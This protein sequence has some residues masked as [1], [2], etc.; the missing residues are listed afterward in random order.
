MHVSWKQRTIPFQ[1]SS[2]GKKWEV[3]WLR[4]AAS[5]LKQS[6]QK[7]VGTR[8]KDRNRKQR[9]V[10]DPEEI[11]VPLPTEWVQKHHQDKIKFDYCSKKRLSMLLRLSVEHC[12]FSHLKVRCK[13]HA[14]SQ[15]CSKSL[16]PTSSWKQTRQTNQ[17][18]SWKSLKHASEKDI[19]SVI[20]H[21]KTVKFKACKTP[22]ENTKKV[23]EFY[24]WDISWQKPYKNLTRKVKGHLD[25]YHHVPMCI[26]EVTLRNAFKLFKKDNGS[27]KISQRTFEQL[28]PKKH[29]RLWCYVQWL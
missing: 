7:K 18:I 9:A 16:S 21:Y 28:R 29:I 20:K 19:N 10:E 22:T 13:V 6:N 25:G 11:A 12:Q 1:K 17:Q 15:T 3:G 23:L 8:I 4:K 24:N 2:W 14:L 26:M 5:Q 27:I